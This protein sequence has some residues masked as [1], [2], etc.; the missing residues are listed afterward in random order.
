MKTA[1]NTSKL[2]TN[3]Y[4]NLEKDE[5]NWDWNFRRKRISTKF[6][7]DKYISYC[8]YWNICIFTIVFEQTLML[9]E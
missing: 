1:N 2:S 7:Y 3:Y 9:P 5:L 6:N 8:C 4:I